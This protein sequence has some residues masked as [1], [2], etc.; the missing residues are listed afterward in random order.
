[1]AW[2]RRLLQIIPG[3][4]SWGTLIGLSVLAI[5][6]PFWIAIFV[7]AYDIYALL[8]AVYMSIHLVYAYRRLRREKKIH[9]LD[10]CRGISGDL[11]TYRRLLSDQL[12][13]LSRTTSVEREKI[14]QL[15][16]HLTEVRQLI[17]ERRHIFNWAN[18]HHAVILPTYDESITVLRTS[19][20]ALTAGDFPLDRLHVVVGFEDRA[21]RTARARAEQLTREFGHKFGTFITAFHPD[22][23]PGETRVK[24]ANAT[25]AIKQLVKELSR[26]KI[27]V[28][29]ILVSN[30]D[31]DTVASPSYF[32]CLTYTFITHPNRYRVSYQPLPMYHNN[33]WDAPAF[34]RVIATGSTFWQMIES[35]RPERLVTFSSHSLTLKALLDI[36]YWQTNIISEDSRVFWQC[37]LRYDGH[38]QTQP[39]YTTVSM[40]AALAQ[41]WWQTFKNQYKQK[42][43]WAWG[44][45][46]FPYLVDGFIKNRKISWRVKTTYLF[47]TLEGHLSW[48]TM[49]IIIAGLGWLPI[50]FGGYAF[51]QTVLSYTLPRMARTIMSI[52]ML[53]LIV[54]TTISLMLLPP[55]PA[56]YRRWRY[57]TMIF[58]WIL[59]PVIATVLSAIP[60]LD[61]ETRMMLGRDLQF[62]VM[63]KARKSEA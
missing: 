10:R 41:S 11:N 32:S 29:S 44:I 58:Q 42:R 63:V 56:R 7:I 25:W 50:F 60:A 14:R 28:D 13:A 1:M 53:G 17:K 34:S 15:N 57:L 46:N 45:E 31:S 26:Q 59:V 8:R 2:R 38:Y 33:V 4:L 49:P 62:N 54:S 51:H 18:V 43:R 21:G 22:G 3:A 27:P 36:G 5:F 9:W 35:T 55:R 12:A 37:L 40:D 30:F 20:K 52:A 48:A 23:L 6:L 61:A 47:R 16:K 24:S 39:I 19:L